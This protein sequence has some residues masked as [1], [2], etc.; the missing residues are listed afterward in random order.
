MPTY[1][2]KTINLF[3]TELGG[4]DFLGLSFGLLIIIAIV[5]A[6]IKPFDF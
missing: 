2:D 3:F 5:L 1:I 6:I 4:L